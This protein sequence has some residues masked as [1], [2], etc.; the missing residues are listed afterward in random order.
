M[1]WWNKIFR[2][3]PIEFNPPEKWVDLHT[4]IL[5]GVDDGS[6]TLE[7][8]LSMARFASA[9]GVT[10][11]VATPHFSDLFPYDPEKKSS[12][13]NQLRQAVKE[14]GIEIEILDGWEVSFTDIHVKRIRAGESFFISEKSR[15]TLIEL[16]NGVNKTAVT[17]GFFSLMVDGVKIVLAHPERNNLIQQDINIISELCL[18][19]VKMQ[20]DSESIMGM[21]GQS[22]KKSAMKLLEREEVHSLSSDAHSLRGYEHYIEACELINKRFGKSMIDKLLMEQPSL[23]AGI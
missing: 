19:G 16:P 2:R 12:A 1:N 7:E 6:K 22:A 21:H 5:P 3:E 8:S 11:I 9:S 13:L 20:I 23:I 17:E 15:Y 14:A 10:H 18:R 4:H